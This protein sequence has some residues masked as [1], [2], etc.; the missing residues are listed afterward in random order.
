MVYPFRHLAR[1][2]TLRA[3]AVVPLNALPPAQQQARPGVVETDLGMQSLDGLELRGV[4]KQKTVPAQISGTGQ[5]VMV[6]DEYWYSEALSIYMIIRHNDPRTGE[7]LV[8]VT[9]VER[10]EPSATQF[11][12]PPAYKVVDETTDDAP[13][14]AH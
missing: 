1:E 8:A 5:A 9:K 4:R 13:A 7:Q 10:T 14:A 12:V 6:T 2:L 3:P 11:T